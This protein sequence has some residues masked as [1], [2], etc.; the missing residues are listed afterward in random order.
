MPKMIHKYRLEPYVTILQLPQGAIPRK[1]D[2]QRGEEFI[3]VEVTID[4]SVPIETRTFQQFATGEPIY[5]Q[6]IYV[7]TFFNNEHADEVW[8]VYDMTYCES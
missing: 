6:A 4:S 5:P 7:G 1:V 2:K 3:W 8:H